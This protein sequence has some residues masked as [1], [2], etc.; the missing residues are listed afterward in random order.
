MD[1]RHLHQVVV[2]AHIRETFARAV[3]LECFVDSDKGLQDF[4]SKIR[5]FCLEHLF[6]PVNVHASVM[7]DAVSAKAVQE[8]VNVFSFDNVHLF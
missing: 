3:Y 5:W 2:V 1:D 8:V 4:H 6:K 7:I